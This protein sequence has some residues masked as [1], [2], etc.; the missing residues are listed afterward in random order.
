MPFKK[1]NAKKKYN[2]EWDMKKKKKKKKGKIII[3]KPISMV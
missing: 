1:I 3:F 2:M